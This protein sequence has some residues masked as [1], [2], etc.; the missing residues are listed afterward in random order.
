MI[1]ST[2]STNGSPPLWIDFE[3]PMILRDEPKLRL[4]LQK[5][6]KN[7]NPNRSFLALNSLSLIQFHNLMETITTSISSRLGEAPIDGLND[8]ER[9]GTR[10]KERREFVG[11]LEPEQRKG[12]ADLVLPR[13][14]LNTTRAIL[15]NE[16]RGQ[17]SFLAHR[18]PTRTPSPPIDTIQEIYLSTRNQTRRRR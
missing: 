2:T 3:I 17:E 16:T 4:L 11:G 5:K 1:L 8:G 12:L 9:K 13:I 7:R 14:S 6:R 15:K 10:R 18:G